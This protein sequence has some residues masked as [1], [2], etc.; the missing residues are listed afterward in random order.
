MENPKNHGRSSGIC[1]EVGAEIEGIKK[2]KP[3]FI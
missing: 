3:I 1:M 2:L